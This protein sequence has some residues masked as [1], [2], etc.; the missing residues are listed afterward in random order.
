MKRRLFLMLFVLT[1]ATC[2]IAG[3][4]VSN[5]AKMYYNQGVDLYKVGQFEQ[6]ARAFQRAINVDSNYIDAYYN[7]GIVLQL[8]NDKA[9]ALNVFKQ[10]IVRKPTD[11]EAVYN[12]AD[13]SVKLGQTEN[14]KK[15]LSIIPQNSPVAPRAQQLAL[16]M[17]TDLSTIQK[18]AAEQKEALKHKIPQ[19]VGAYNEI[20]SPTGITSDKDGNVYI[21][22]FGDNSILKITPAGVK[23]V[24]AKG[25]MLNGPIDIAADTNGNI[26]VA[27]YSANNIIKITPNGA[28][29]HFLSNVN[30][31][32]CLHIADGMIFISSQGANTVIRQKLK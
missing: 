15:Y 11:Y 19:T 13:L 6:S 2:N 8:M 31:P 30:Q 1:L 7:L 18:E 16:S 12:A 25:E 17:N 10:I 4:E 32:Y 3:A 9:G 14:A 5:E 27:N 24:F 28:F 22:S 23:S 21:A 29:A 26:Y 20:L